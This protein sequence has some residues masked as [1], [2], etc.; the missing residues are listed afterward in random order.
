MSRLLTTM[1]MLTG[2]VSKILDKSPSWDGSDNM[3]SSEGLGSQSLHGRHILENGNTPVEEPLCFGFLGSTRGENSHIRQEVL[4]EPNEPIDATT[5]R[6]EAQSLQ[7]SS[8][9]H[10]I[11]NIWTFEYQMGPQ[12]YIDAFSANQHTSVILG[13]DWTHSNSPFSD[14]IQVLQNLL[15]NKLELMPTVLDDCGKTLYQSISIVLAMFNSI[16]R[17]DVMIW[18]AQTRFYHIIELTAWEMYPSSRTFEKLHERYR[19]TDIQ[20]RHPHP[21][22]IDWIPFPSIRDRL[23]QLHAANP[24][25]DQIFCDAV[26]GYVVEALMSDLVIGA[27]RIKAYIRVT[28]LITSMSS[29]AGNRGT[30]TPV[31]LPAPDATTLFKSPECARMVFQRLNMDRGASYYKIDPAFFGKYPELYD[32]TSDIA[33][34]GIPLRPELQIG[35]SYPKPLDSLM[36]RTYRSFIEFSLNAVMDT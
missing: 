16:T 33:A 3:A 13:Q 9:P 30:G 5:I 29:S 27:P 8:L 14:H 35:L 26:S 25:I 22:V 31:R 19:P 28:D 24:Q 7:I 18:Y 32:Q 11:P 2:S 6:S 36:I 34:T 21:R 15:R 17:P 12:P 1:Q 20:L 23:I 4:Q 10:Q